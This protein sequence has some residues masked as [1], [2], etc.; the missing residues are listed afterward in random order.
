M[1][2]DA[3]VRD[4]STARP[5]PTLTLLT[6]THRVP[7]GVLTLP[8]WQLLTGPGPVLAGDPAHPQLPALVAA[9]VEVEQLPGGQPAATLAHQLVE[10]AL[11]GPE[12]LVWL[13]SPD[14]DPELGRALGHEVQRREQAGEPAPVVELLPGSYDLPGARLL[15]LV[16][17]MDRL[18]S[19]GGCPWDAGQDHLSLARY[20]AEETYETIEAIETG[21]RAALREEL[22]DVLLQ[23]AFHARIAEEHPEQPWSIDDVAGDLVAKLLHRHPHVFADTQVA[24]A[25]EVEANWEALK[26]AEKGRTSATEGVP[27]AQP[28]LALA[29]K[30]LSRAARAGLPVGPEAPVAVPD[31]LDQDSLGELL[32]SVAA[33]AQRGGLDAEAALR[34][35]ARGFR[36]RMLAAEADVRR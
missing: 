12:P 16:S 5:H 35:A 21:D 36:D 24:D 1:A 32:L 18:R 10:R 15:D 25:S 29:T 28:A 27:L 7:A 9:G 2:G 13:V 11:A 33:L 26:A 23:V 17:V 6:T 4:G 30:L 20:L 22:G 19:P 31:R 3:W 34:G 8:A 14:G